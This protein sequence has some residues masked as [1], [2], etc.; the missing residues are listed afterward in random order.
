[1]SGVIGVIGDLS[2]SHCPSAFVTGDRMTGCIDADGNGKNVKN[3]RR[4]DQRP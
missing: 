2:N 4:K 3:R 1:M